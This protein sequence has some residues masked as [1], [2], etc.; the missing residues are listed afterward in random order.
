MI[1]NV[2]LAKANRETLKAFYSVIKESDEYLRFVLL[3]GV[4]KFSKVSVFSGMNNLNDISMNKRY[5]A[6]LGYTQ[7][8]VE[9]YF[10]DRID[11]LSEV[12]QKPVEDILLD[13]KYWYN[14]YRFGNDV[15][16]VSIIPFRRY[17][18]L[19]NKCFLT[20]GLRR[21]RRHF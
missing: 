17:C 4:T 7:D 3:T 2:E 20:T 1:D 18:C 8:E 13:I 11:L 19:I 6:L 21:G 5:A 10:R 16:R 12:V 14:G 9:S 15:T